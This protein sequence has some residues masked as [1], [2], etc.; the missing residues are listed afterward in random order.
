MRLTLDDDF[1]DLRA[2]DCVVQRGTWHKWTNLGDQPCVFQ[3]AMLATDP[4]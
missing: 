4:L 2:G 3:A 1:V